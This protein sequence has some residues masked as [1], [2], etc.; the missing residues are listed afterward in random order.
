M[1]PKPMLQIERRINGLMV[2]EIW[3]LFEEAEQEIYEQEVEVREEELEMDVVDILHIYIGG[4]VAFTD[5][6]I[7]EY[8][9]FSG[10][11][12]FE[13]AV[14]FELD[15]VP[16]LEDRD[17]AELDR[18]IDANS[19]GLEK[20]RDLVDEAMLQVIEED[21]RYDFGIDDSV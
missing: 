14:P 6:L 7:E 15:E 1:E 19:E 4:E 9:V 13:E 11:S 17:R 16:D 10:F 20:Y 5:D 3:S 18:F 21:D 2:P 12:E 8:T